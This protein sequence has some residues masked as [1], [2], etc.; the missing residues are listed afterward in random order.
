MYLVRLKRIEDDVPGAEHIVIA[1][2][3]DDHAITALKHVQVQYAVAGAEMR[4]FIA[5]VI[6]DVQVRNI[7]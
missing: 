3:L 7:L 5:L 1:V 2:Q 6:V 4:V